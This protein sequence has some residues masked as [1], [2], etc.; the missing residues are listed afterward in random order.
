MLKLGYQLQVYGR[1]I[2]SMLYYVTVLSAFNT[3]GAHA[4]QIYLSYGRC[5]MQSMIRK[6]SAL[7]YLNN[8]LLSHVYSP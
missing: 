1:A 8:I 2:K 4:M 3:H 5:P 7:E 6:G